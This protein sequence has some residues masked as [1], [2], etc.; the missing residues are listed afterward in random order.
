[1]VHCVCNVLAVSSGYIVYG[2]MITNAL[3]G[4]GTSATIANV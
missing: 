2:F 3:P 4:T 1:M